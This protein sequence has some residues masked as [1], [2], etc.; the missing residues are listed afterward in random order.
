[1]INLLRLDKPLTV[2]LV[3]SGGREHALAWKISQSPHLGQLL[4]TPGNA[5]TATLGTNYSIPVEDIETI[6]QFALAKS[7]DLVVIGPEVPLSL[8]LVDALHAVG[9]SAFGP[10]RAAAQIESSKSFAKDF[11]HR[12][13]IPTASYG[14]FTEYAQ[15]LHFLEEMPGQAVIKA[16]G[17][18]AGKG[19]YLPD[20]PA[21]AGRILHELLVEQNL[22]K[23]GTEVVIE[24]RLEG[25]EV[26]LL[27][28]SDGQT[29][30]WLP[31][32]QDHKRLKDG[33]QGP[34]T[35]GMGAYAPAPVC[36]P[37][38]AGE[39]AASLIQPAIDGL[40]QDGIPFCGV[41][42]AG[43]MLTAQGPYVLEYNCRLGDPETQALLPLLDTDL[44]EIIVACVNGSLAELPVQ[45]KS[46]ACASVVLAAENYPQAGT[47]SRPI[48][49]LD[50]A[51]QENGIVLHCGTQNARGQVFTMGGR[52]LAVTAWGEDLQAALHTAYRQIETIHFEGMHYRRDIGAKGL[53]HLSAYA[54]AG[55]SIDAGLRSVDLIRA[56]VR[57]TYT[58]AVLSG[59]GSFGGLFDAAAL[60]T[61]RHPVLVASTD[62]V[63]TKTM[64]AAQA[65]QY[66]SLGA[67]LVN[68]CI[69]DI[70]VQGARPLFF[71][72]YFAASHLDPLVVAE[73]VSG[74]AAACCEAGCALIGGETAE[75]PGVYRSGE[76][77]VAGTIVGVVEKEAVLP[78]PT[79]CA[80]DCLVGLRSSGPHTNG[81]SLLRQI[82][83]HDP[84]DAIPEGLEVPLG[85]ALLAPH[86]SYLPLLAPILDL[87]DGPVKALAHITGGGLVDNLPRILPPEL[88][89]HVHLGAW[90][91][92]PLF[93]LVE[94]RGP[95]SRQ[96][97]ARVF[98]LGIGMV[99][100][101]SPQD[102]ARFQTALPE[103]TWVIGELAP[104]RGKVILDS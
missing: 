20:S 8:G 39:L 61:M 24:E 22:G 54:G 94:R 67:D 83:R 70:L 6:V 66:A 30:R 17:L 102:L 81:Y 74:M 45:W 96:E 78:A 52:I 18:A 87:P 59:V 46:G 63:G 16:S 100:L 51:P 79:L 32:A 90:P 93:T 76:F 44:L 35:G 101:V 60:Q 49:G 84:L 80:G 5:G 64:L 21:E 103:Q 71:L 92:P 7:I 29:I 86:R 13:A 99:A 47:P 1:M 82:F 33:D 88:D 57:S 72:D 40:R 31:P 75:M 11:M 26:S 15:A 42:Y 89:A 23:A 85:Q 14:V 91:V 104:G 19:V 69:N 73:I 68:H 95:V 34:N 4:T 27:A 62:G 98:N 28:F 50:A 38:M 97:M 10:T 58:P 12:Y 43:L 9:I 3:G 36:P 77:D 56:A 37:E 48:S 2:L 65:R 25:E 55:V 53:E 41:L